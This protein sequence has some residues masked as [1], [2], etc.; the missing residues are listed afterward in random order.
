[1]AIY[2]NVQRLR[3]PAPAGGLHGGL[4]LSAVAYSQSSR[5]GRPANPKAL[6]DRGHSA[7]LR[8]GQ[9]LQ[10][11]VYNRT[12]E[13]VYLALLNLDADFGISRMYPAHTVNQKV[14]ANGSVVIDQITPRLSGPQSGRAVEILKVIATRTP[15]SFDV[16]QL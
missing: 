10:L 16:L 15:T 7:T 11:T 2:R 4:E 13:P 12:D 14:E 6:F 9:K 3:N 8:A 1:L 5:G